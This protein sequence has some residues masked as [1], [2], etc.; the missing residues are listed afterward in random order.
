MSDGAGCIF[1]A[2]LLSFIVEAACGAGLAESGYRVVATTGA[3]AGQ[4]V[5]H[6]HWL[7]IGGR[8]QG[9]SA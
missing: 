6:L 7:V 9:G 8:R 5:M 1:C 2:E 4:E 3:D